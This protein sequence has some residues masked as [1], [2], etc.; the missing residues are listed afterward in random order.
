MILARFAGCKPEAGLRP[1]RLGKIRVRS[2]EVDKNTFRGRRLA[3]AGLSAALLTSTIA[4]SS[5]EAQSLT[6]LHNFGA[7]GADGINS[8]SGLVRDAAG[9]LYGTTYL[10]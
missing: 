9:N 3:V 2:N 1:K 5:A 4:I 10:G 7:S 8:Y 6:I